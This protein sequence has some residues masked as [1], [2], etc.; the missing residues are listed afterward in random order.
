MACA[1]CHDHKFDPIATKDFYS[2]SAFFRNTTQFAL[3]GN[4]SDPPPIVVVP[5]LE[6]RSRWE[7]LKRK[8]A[9]VA[10][11]MQAKVSSADEKFE[12]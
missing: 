6:E 12:T 8:L 2:L 11:R 3:D 10:S 7:E 4:V 1:T 5:R 9:Q